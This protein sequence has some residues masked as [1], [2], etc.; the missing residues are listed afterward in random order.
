MRS[1]G[2]FAVSDERRE[3]VEAGLQAI[4]HADRARRDLPADRQ[5]FVRGRFDQLQQGAPALWLAMSLRERQ[6]KRAARS[7]D[8]APD[9][10]ELACQIWGVEVR[11]HLDDPRAG[12]ADPQR[13]AHQLGLAGAERWRGIAGDGAMIDRARG[14]KPDRAGAHGICGQAAH[15]CNIARRRGFKRSAAFA[16]DEHPQRPVR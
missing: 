5:A 16:H 2:N 3:R 10:R 7:L 9:H 14:G 4:K 13:N 15:L 8:Q 1:V 6:R 11:D 12:I